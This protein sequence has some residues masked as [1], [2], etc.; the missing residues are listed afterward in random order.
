MLMNGGSIDGTRVLAPEVVRRMTAGYVPVPGR[1]AA[2]SQRYSYGLVVG[3]RGSDRVWMHGGSINGFDAEVVMFPDRD[4]AVAIIDN[5]SGRPLNVIDSVFQR[6]GGI[7]LRPVMSPAPPRDAT[8]AERALL[9][10]RYGQGAIDVELAE[11][12][13]ALVFRQNGITMRVQ[14]SEPQTLVITPPVGAPVRLAWVM[15]SDGRAAYLS[16]S[17]RSLARR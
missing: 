8:A 17:S 13:G 12:N 11:D 16:Q 1:P 15:G 6:A 3:R 14:I 5:L 9:V 2:D 10:G 7:P 4:F